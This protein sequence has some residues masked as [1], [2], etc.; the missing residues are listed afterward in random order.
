[1]IDGSDV[2]SEGR[3]PKLHSPE[4]AD[5]TH[6]WAR[7]CLEMWEAER[8]DLK[9]EVE[10]LRDALERIAAQPAAMRPGLAWTHWRQIAR[11][12]L[13]SDTAALPEDR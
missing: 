13:A 7:A 1:V 3:W 10:R 6:R 11:D 5:A 8:A 9:A 12:A 2:T 4:D